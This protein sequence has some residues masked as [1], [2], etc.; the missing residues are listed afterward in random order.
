LNDQRQTCLS[1]LILLGSWLYLDL[2][3]KHLQ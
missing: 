1:G 2:P 3:V